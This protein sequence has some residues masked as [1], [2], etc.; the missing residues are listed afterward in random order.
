MTNGKGENP[1]VKASGVL[2]DGRQFSG[3]DEFKQLLADDID[4]FAEAFVEQLAT[5]ALR[6]MMTID[7]REQIKAIAKASKKDDYRLQNVIKNFI[8]S[9]LFLN[10]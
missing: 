6:R 8:K 3:P 7:D 2:P 9:P 4:L 10:R 1:P 5:F